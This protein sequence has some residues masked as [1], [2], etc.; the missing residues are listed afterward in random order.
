MI[1]SCGGVFSFDDGAYWR[2]YS[3]PDQEARCPATKIEEDM[4]GDEDGNAA[5]LKKILARRTSRASDQ[6]ASLASR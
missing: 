2:R 3:R 5:G 1:V 4:L 6:T